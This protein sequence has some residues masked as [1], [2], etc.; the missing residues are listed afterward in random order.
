[1]SQRTLKS[2]LFEVRRSFARVGSF[3]GYKAAPVAFSGGVALVAG[4][5][6]LAWQPSAMQFVLLWTSAATVG[7]GMN[8]WCIARDYGAS[9]RQWERSLAYAALTDL[10]P[11]VLAGALLTVVMSLTDRIDLLPGLWMMLFGTGIMASRRHLPR[12]S[13]WLGAAYLLAGTATL[14]LLVGEAAL[15]AEVMAGVFGLGQLALS[16]VLGRGDS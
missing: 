15:R 7:F 8:L 9:P 5:A 16:L 14:L 6:Q 10:S 2:N 11:A 3:G 13:G 4:L 12:F 1:M